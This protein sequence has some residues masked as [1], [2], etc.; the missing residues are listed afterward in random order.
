MV[1][2]LKLFTAN[3]LIRGDRRWHRTAS[4]AAC[5]VSWWRLH[6]LRIDTRSEPTGAR[7][8]LRPS[9]WPSAPAWSACRSKDARQAARP[10]PTVPP[11][12]GPRSPARRPTRPNGPSCPD[13]ALIDADAAGFDQH[14]P[15]CD[16][17]LHEAIEIGRRRPV[18]GNELEAN[19]IEFFPNG[20]RLHRLEHGLIELANDRLRRALWQEECIPG[21]RLDVVTLLHGGRDVGQRG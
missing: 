21:V 8:A 10:K 4:H 19:G 5:G 13:I 7:S 20:W 17:A 1:C 9:G 6:Q 12:R 15:F 11:A 14:G 2:R 18:F 3:H 16:F